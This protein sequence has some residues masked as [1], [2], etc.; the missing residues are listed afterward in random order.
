MTLKTIRVSRCV[1]SRTVPIHQEGKGETRPVRADLNRS[2]RGLLWSG[3]LRRVSLDQLA[4]VTV[5]DLRCLPG[6]CNCPCGRLRFT[7]LVSQHERPESRAYLKCGPSQSV[8]SRR[9]L[10]CRGVW[11]AEPGSNSPVPLGSAPSARMSPTTRE[12]PEDRLSPPIQRPRPH[13]HRPGVTVLRSAK[14][15][16]L[17]EQ[18]DAIGGSSWA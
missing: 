6:A 1:P 9:A 2:R 5:D 16:S 13:P 10:L 15:S 11:V 7:K 3:F 17:A 12:P 18:P 14:R 8:A 4:G